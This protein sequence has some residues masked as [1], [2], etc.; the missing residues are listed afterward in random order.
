MQRGPPPSHSG[1]AQGPDPISR[2]RSTDIQVIGERFH[3]R[4]GMSPEPRQQVTRY[5]NKSPNTLLRIQNF[6]DAP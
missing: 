4:G 2:P 3:T 5:E 1:I 6:Y